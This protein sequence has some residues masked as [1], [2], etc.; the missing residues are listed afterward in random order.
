M[1]E[2]FKMEVRNFQAWF[3]LLAVSETINTLSA[4]D[5]GTSAGSEISEDY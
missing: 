2:D 3:H 5:K 1:S 4:L